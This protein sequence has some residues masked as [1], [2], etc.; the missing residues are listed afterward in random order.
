MGALISLWARCA[1]WL[2]LMSLVGWRLGLCSLGLWRRLRRLLIRFLLASL[3]L[4]C[5]L[6]SF[7][8]QESTLERT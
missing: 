8:V 2:C 6:S 7:A 5:A 4:D 1:G 3:R